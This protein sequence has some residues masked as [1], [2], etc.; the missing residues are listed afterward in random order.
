VANQDPEK[1][2]WRY[3]RREVKDYTYWFDPN[4]KTH[5]EKGYEYKP[6]AK[7]PKERIPLKVL[8]GE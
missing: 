6:L 3:S 8:L 7:L 1:S 5:Y 4:D 2:I